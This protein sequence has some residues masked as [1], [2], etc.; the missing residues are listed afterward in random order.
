MIYSYLM[1]LK[2]V[3]QYC[4]NQLIYTRDCKNITPHGAVR[5]D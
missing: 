1:C 4:D 5:G 2:N 3:H